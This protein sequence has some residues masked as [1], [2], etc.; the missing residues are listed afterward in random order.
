MKGWQVLLVLGGL[1]VLIGLGLTAA[2]VLPGT[3]A[4]TV[5]I[6]PGAGWYYYYEFDLLGT[7]GVRGSYSVVSTTS[8]NVFVF[9]QSQFSAYTSS[10][11]TSSLWASPGA[12]SGSF[13]VSLPG[14]GKYYLVFEHAAGTEAVEQE[15]EVTVTVSGVTP[16][17]LAGGIGLTIIGV[18]LAVVGTLRKRKATAPL[19]GAP[20]AP[21]PARDVVM[22]QEPKPPS[23][24]SP[25]GT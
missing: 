15:V 7:G 1:L 13:D 16:T 10:G 6:P 25:P 12:S 5:T 19:L 22:F 11:S 3:T 4:E 20:A 2:A 17:L 18:I 9:T 21:V 8:V 14:S 24:P 23:P